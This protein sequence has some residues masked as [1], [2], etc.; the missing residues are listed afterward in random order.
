MV[1]IQSAFR[2][3]LLVFILLSNSNVVA[4]ERDSLS[5]PQAFPSFRSL[6]GEATS[7]FLASNVGVSLDFDFFRM[8]YSSVLV[9][10]VRIGMDRM[11]TTDLNFGGSS[12]SGSPYT[13]YQFLFRIMNNRETSRFDVLFGYLYRIK[14]DDYNFHYDP[15]GRF[16]FEIQYSLGIKRT[17]LA[18]LF[19]LGSYT[20]G[21]G[22]IIRIQ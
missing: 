16:I 6:Q 7:I 15:I 12:H 2:Y 1:N 22:V 4:Q 5:I 18:V 21:V 20:L 10:G 3:L 19:R 17:P 9:G 14:T 11:W 13:D 8:P